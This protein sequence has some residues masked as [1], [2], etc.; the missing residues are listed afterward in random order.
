MKQST[1]QGIVETVLLGPTA[2]PGVLVTTLN[3]DFSSLELSA[4]H[5]DY[6]VITIDGVQK[7]VVG[8]PK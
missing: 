3:L 8:I 6:V 5:A 4:I 2:R 1:N 7:L